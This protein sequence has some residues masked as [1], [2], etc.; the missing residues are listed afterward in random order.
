MKNG[1]RLGHIILPL[2]SPICYNQK[3][4]LEVVED[5]YYEG[6]KKLYEQLSDEIFVALREIP[7]SAYN[8]LFKML[9][10]LSNSLTNKLL[11]IKIDNSYLYEIFF[12]AFF[13]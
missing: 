7:E 9:K 4:K 12:F 13:V 10:N 11:K 6:H 5:N 3:S 1:A 2:C 8:D